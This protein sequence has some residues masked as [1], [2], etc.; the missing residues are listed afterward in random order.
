MG[1]CRSSFFQCVAFSIKFNI[2]R[3]GGWDSVGVVLFS[4]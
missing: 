4:V 1:W 3:K 2:V